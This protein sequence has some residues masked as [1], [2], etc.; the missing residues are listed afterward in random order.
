MQSF[1]CWARVLWQT[2]NYPETR[3]AFTVHIDLGHNLLENGSQV[4]RFSLYFNIHPSFLLRV[5]SLSH[6]LC[7]FS[8]F[9]R[10]P[11]NK[12]MLWY[13]VYYQRVRISN[14]TLSL[15]SFNRFS[16]SDGLDQHEKSSLLF[17]CASKLI[18]IQSIS[19]KCISFGMT[20]ASH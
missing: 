16:T 12:F 5:L 15:C 14:A 6:R 19:Q 17:V 9:H 18:I 3:H 20:T 4:F 2:R 11:R 10:S 8:I 7:L 1:M 13:C